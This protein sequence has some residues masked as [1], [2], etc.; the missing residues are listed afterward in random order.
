MNA[1]MNTDGEGWYVAYT[2]YA[3]F[4]FFTRSNDRISN[5]F[6]HLQS[7]NNCQRGEASR[8]SGLHTE[9]QKLRNNLHAL[10]R[11]RFI[12]CH[13]HFYDGHHCSTMSAIS[14]YHFYHI[15]LHYIYL[16]IHLNTS[17][18]TLLRFN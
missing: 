16:S 2:T 5:H 1:L 10:L 13:M 9:I 11:C 7:L 3:R 8:R 18:F 6:V 12:L 14:F 15:L 4:F 17:R